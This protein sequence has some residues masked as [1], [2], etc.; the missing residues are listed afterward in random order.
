MILLRTAEIR[1][2]EARHQSAVASPADSLMERAGRAAAKLAQEIGA[3]KSPVLVYAGPGNNGGDAFVLA[4]VLKQLGRE[5]VVHFAGDATRLPQDA[6]AAYRRCADTGVEVSAA[7]PSSQ[8][9]LVVDGLFGIGLT[10]PLEGGYVDL[11]SRI[12]A[13][14]GPVL[15]LDIPSGLDADTGMVLGCAVRATHTLTFIAAKPGLYTLDGPDHCGVIQVDTLGLDRPSS[16]G[17]ILTRADYTRYL[18]QRKQNTHKGTHGSLAVIGGAQGMVGAAILAARAGLKLGAGRIFVGTVGTMGTVGTVATPSVVAVDPMQ[19]E[20]MFRQADEA[21]EQGTALVIGPGLGL[22]TSALE[23][24]Q[25]VT[26][27]NWRDQTANPI[28]I[29]FDADALTLI[30]SHPVV[31]KRIERRNAPMIL[32]PHPAEAARLLQCATAAV[33]ADRVS[34]ALRLARRFQAIVALKGCG[35][36]VA[37]PDSHWRINTTG[38]SGLATGGTGDVLAGMIGGLLAQGW[39]AWEATCAGVHLHGMAADRCVEAGLGP[40]GLT[41]SE[42]IDPARRLL[43]DWIADKNEMID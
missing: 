21:L 15:A 7:P 35:T 33:Q 13:F 39:P 19:P 31:A 8:F 20:L 34:S 12:N 42:L 9:G 11:I 30:G 6:L 23:L 25:R 37:R 32:T 4:R 18:Q 16:E 28:P 41:A 36:V 1:S 26:S 22:S 3:S 24:I 2:I 27:T 40:V 10:R 43:N 38:N 29:L 5:V 17:A 14:G